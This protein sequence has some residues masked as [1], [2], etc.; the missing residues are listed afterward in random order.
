VAD[1]ETSFW[2]TK[3]AKFKGA[4]ADIARTI[5]DS[6]FTVHKALAPVCSNLRFAP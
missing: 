6:A 1:A 5:V 3:G 4:L 2:T